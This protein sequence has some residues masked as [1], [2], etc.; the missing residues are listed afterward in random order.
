MP[1]ALSTYR[2]RVAGLWNTEH[3]L[4]SAEGE[5][6]LLRMER[7]P[8]GL[9]VAG[10]WIP[11]RGERLH[12]RRDPGLLRSQ[13]S[14][15]TEG[16]EW[17]GSSLR[18]SFL[19]REVVL[20]TGARPL[21]LLPTGGFGAGWTLQAPRTGEMAR[22]EGGLL[23]RAMTITV[24]RKLEVELLA[25]TYFLAWQIRRESFWPGPRV[26]DDPSFA[27]ASKPPSP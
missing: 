18:W 16:R 11:S 2:S 22:F 6:G 26:E 12:F 27:A 17:L 1:E 3:R 15:W 4:D 5:L 19:R 9:V 10:D 24:V 20:H 23:G 13:F 7:N 21:R 8:F 25:F 14:V